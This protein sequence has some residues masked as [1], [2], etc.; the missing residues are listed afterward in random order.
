MSKAKFVVCMVLVFAL[1]AAVGVGAAK[2]AKGIDSNLYVGQSPD[3][4]AEALLEI[5]QQQAGKGTWE[6]INTA[7]VYMLSGR[8]QE[9]QAIIDGVMAGKAGA[10]DVIRV[11]RVYY[12]MGDW[13]RAKEMFDR[14]LEMAPKDQDW[15]AEIG[16][17]YNLQGEREKAERL[18]G[19][20]FGLGLSLKNTL[21]AAGSYVGVEPRRR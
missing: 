7:R 21:A 11:G 4:A 16:A 3:E 19:S 10:G 12:Q 17:Y 20:S 8:K 9:G 1:G 2:K 5:A 6:R 14:A 15:M 18:F 13:E